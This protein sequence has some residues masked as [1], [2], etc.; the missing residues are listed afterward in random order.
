MYNIEEMKKKLKGKKIL[1]RG[2][3]GK[4]KVFLYSEYNKELLQDAH[5]ELMIHNSGNLPDDGYYVVTVKDVYLDRNQKKR[6]DV[7]N[8]KFLSD[9]PIGLADIEPHL[10][11]SYQIENILERKVKTRSEILMLM[12]L[13]EGSVNRPIT[14]AP[15]SYKMY[16]RIIE[17]YNSQAWGDM[18][19]NIFQ[20][21]VMHYQT[22]RYPWVNSLQVILMDEFEDLEL[23]YEKFVM[24][25]IG[26]VLPSEAGM[27][28][29]EEA[30]SKMFYDDDEDYSYLQEILGD[31]L[32]C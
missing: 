12:M 8:L 19:E 30:I 13:L 7:N 26:D 28:E 16:A 18:W 14:V 32:V 22:T 2:R 23:D 20:L 1:V 24:D 6:I 27:K 31:Y 25:L 5:E 9:S 21:Q 15:Q 29:L 4:T 3:A 11:S 17:D 10:Y